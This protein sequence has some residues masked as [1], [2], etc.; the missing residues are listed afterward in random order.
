M[1]FFSVDY[2]DVL[3]VIL[4]YCHPV[5]L[6]NLRRCSKFLRR[7]IPEVCY[8]QTLDG[9][10]LINN[11]PWGYQA[12]TCQYITDEYTITYHQYNRKCYSYTDDISIEYYCDG[13]VITEKRT[14]DETLK[15]Y[16]YVNTYGYVT[17]R[18]YNFDLNLYTCDEYHYI[19]DKLVVISIMNGIITVTSAVNGH[20]FT[21]DTN[22]STVTFRHKIN[23]EL[24][25][26]TKQRITRHLLREEISELNNFL[27]RER[28][29]FKYI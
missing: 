9:G 23:V 5:S 1:N 25:Y 12:S 16:S 6:F 2:K 13:D 28:S 29:I 26:T 22:K 24:P 7:Y 21:I 15:L 8:S 10:F 27:K 19:F 14:Q 17:V 3:S 20:L 11:K 18:R 4:S